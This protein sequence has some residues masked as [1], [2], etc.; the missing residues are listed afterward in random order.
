MNL[1]RRI[2]LA[3]IVLLTW[4]A[5]NLAYGGQTIAGGVGVTVGLTFI[6]LTCWIKRTDAVPTTF[7]LN[8]TALLAEAFMIALWT[9]RLVHGD[10]TRMWAMVGGA[11]FLTFG[12]ACWVAAAMSRAFQ[13]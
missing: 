13:K 5:A 12:L 4:M 6:F 8:G 9:P 7:F 11:G 3:V 10:D 2:V 1:L